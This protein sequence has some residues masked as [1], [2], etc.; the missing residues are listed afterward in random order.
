MTI[1]NY[2]SDENGEA[3]RA[4]CPEAAD[5]DG[6]DGYYPWLDDIC[7]GV[8]PCLDC[9]PWMLITVAKLERVQIDIV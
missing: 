9:V 3:I 8:E 6:F 4:E 7:G 2:S 1:C 5:D